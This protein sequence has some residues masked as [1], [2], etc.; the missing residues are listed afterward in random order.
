MGSPFLT[1]D[2][3][4]SVVPN[5]RLVNFAVV[6]SFGGVYLRENIKRLDQIE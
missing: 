5:A 3:R 4:L 2:I 6:F 1:D